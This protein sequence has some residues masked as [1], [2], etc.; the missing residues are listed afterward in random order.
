MEITKLEGSTFCNVGYFGDALISYEVM[1]G[2]K[3]PY[4]F[5]LKENLKSKERLHDLAC[6]KYIVA[7]KG[8]YGDITKLIADNMD[9]YKDRAERVYYVIEGA[10][11]MEDIM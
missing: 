3:M 10:M 6:A 1:K 9:F 7:H 4:A 5:I 8:I 11:T 2:V